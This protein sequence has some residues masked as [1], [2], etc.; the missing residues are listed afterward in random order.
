MPSEGCWSP[1]FFSVTVPVIEPFF[2]HP[3]S[4]RGEGS[5]RSTV[6]STTSAVVSTQPAG[7]KSRG[8][9]SW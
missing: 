1:P 6:T 4:A 7:A 8:M 2:T 5:A 3:N 9:I